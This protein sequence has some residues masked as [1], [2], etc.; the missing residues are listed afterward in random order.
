MTRSDAPTAPASADADP[1][2]GVGSREANAARRSETD[3]D[4]KVLGIRH[5]ALGIG[6]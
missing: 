1:P 2:P 4:R 6:H 5:E 3:E